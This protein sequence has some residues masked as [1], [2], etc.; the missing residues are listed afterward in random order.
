[1]KLA[2]VVLFAILLLPSIAACAQSPPT[3]KGMTSEQWAAGA[4]NAALCEKPPCSARS[5]EEIFG[6]MRTD[7]E[8]KLLAEKGD[9]QAQSQQCGS[10]GIKKDV[11]PDYYLKV[12]SWCRNDAD[13]GSLQAAYLLGNLYSTG[14]GGLS[15]SWPDAYFW[16]AVRIVDKHV[17][18][19]QRDAAAKHLTAE[20]ISVAEQRI[21][22]WK[23]KLCASSP[24]TRNAKVQREMHCQTAR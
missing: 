16:Y 4:V 12:V 18:V 11:A 13:Q 23:E 2:N 19:T 5:I 1:M 8:W 9:R 3:Q 14:E 24:T 15:Q 22:D 10:H 17:A 20:Q 6:P 7:N 21:K